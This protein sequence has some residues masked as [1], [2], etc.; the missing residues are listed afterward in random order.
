MVLCSVRFLPNQLIFGILWFYD[1]YSPFQ[2]KTRYDFT[3]FKI[4]SLSVISGFS[5]SMKSCPHGG[6][7]VSTVLISP[8]WMLTMVR[9]KRNTKLRASSRASSTTALCGDEGRSDSTAG[10]KR[11][12]KKE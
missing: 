9:A 6:G 3:I 7:D 4:P 5:D 11:K 12:K 1:L 8:L 2:T 10:N